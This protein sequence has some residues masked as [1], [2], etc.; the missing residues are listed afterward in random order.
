MPCWLTEGDRPGPDDV[1]A[2]DNGLFDLERF[3]A[4][5]E[6]VLLPHT[7]EWF[8]DNCLPH[9]FDPRTTRIGP[10]ASVTS[11]TAIHAVS[12]PPST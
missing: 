12:V 8:S 11:L 9:A 4:M 5:G 7:P 3:E 1:I 2:F 6:M 10:L